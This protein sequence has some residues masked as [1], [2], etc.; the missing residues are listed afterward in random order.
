MKRRHKQ[1]RVL[2]KDKYYRYCAL[3]TEY[4]KWTT[5]LAWWKAY[6]KVFPRLAQFA[7]DIFSIPAMLAKVEKLFSSTKLMLPLTRNLLQPDRIE[8]KECI[9][10]WTLSGLILGDYFEYL[11]IEQ[12]QNKHY[13]LQS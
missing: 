10:S 6:A 13:R 5:P 8:A 12:R 7:K 3:D 11:T 4:T 1:S 9:R 2:L